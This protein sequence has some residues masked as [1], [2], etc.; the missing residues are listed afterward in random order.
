MIIFWQSIFQ[1]WGL[2]RSVFAF[3]HSLIHSFI[4]NHSVVDVANEF[5]KFVSQDNRLLPSPL[6]SCFLVTYIWFHFMWCILCKYSN[7][8]FFFYCVLCFFLFI[9]FMECSD[10]WYFIHP[11]YFMNSYIGPHFERLQCLDLASVFFTLY[12]M[13]NM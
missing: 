11:L 6:L 4:R 13:K 3:I 10:V 9:K 2:D 12:K 1:W 7:F 5:L 8:L